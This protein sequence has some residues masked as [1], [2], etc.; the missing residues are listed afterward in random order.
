MKPNIL[1]VPYDGSAHAGDA[2]RFACVVARTTDSRVVAVYVTRVPP[3]LPLLA[4]IERLDRPGHAALR[5]ACEVAARSGVDLNASLVRSRDVATGI[6]TE[7]RQ[8]GADAI[9]MA[10]NPRRRPW[11]RLLLARTARKVMRRAQ[12]PVHINVLEAELEASDRV[13]DAIRVIRH[14]S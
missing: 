4:D 12:C 1:L 8:V 7:A 3:S 11:L 14:A 2:L 13:A 10:L 5:G 6:L 9:F